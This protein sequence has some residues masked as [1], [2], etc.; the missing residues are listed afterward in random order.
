MLHT[1]TIWQDSHGIDHASYG[2]LQAKSA[3]GVTPILAR[4]MFDAG[5]PDG[6][7]EVRGRDGRLRFTARSLVSLSKVRVQC[8]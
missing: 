6:P 5:I 4:M 2:D 8:P 7:V 3:S 1:M